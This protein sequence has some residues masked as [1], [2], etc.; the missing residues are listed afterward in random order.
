RLFDVSLKAYREMR[1]AG[2][3]AVGEFHYLHHTAAGD[4][5][6]GDEAV[7]AAAGEAGIRIVLL[8]A[9][10]KTGGIGNPLQGAQRRF[11]TASL[12]AYWNQLEHLAGHLDSATQSLGVVAHRIRAV[13]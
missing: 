13:P 5:F 3:T 4:D 8:Q 6:V 2:I 7:L 9:Y 10:Y 11:E 12:P 1:R